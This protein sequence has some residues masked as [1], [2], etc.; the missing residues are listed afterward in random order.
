MKKYF[1]FLQVVFFRKFLS[2]C[3]PVTSLFNSELYGLLRHYQN[4]A[5]NHKQAPKGATSDVMQYVSIIG[6]ITVVYDIGE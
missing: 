3:S 1:W 6:L 5:A 2:F 4:H